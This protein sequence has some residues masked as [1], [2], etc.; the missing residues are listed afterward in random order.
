M[1]LMQSNDDALPF[2]VPMHA[3]SRA[4]GSRLALIMHSGHPA[5]CLWCDLLRHISL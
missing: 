5:L 1:K 2:N 4:Q 3:A